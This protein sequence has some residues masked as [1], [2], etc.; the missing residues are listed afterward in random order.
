MYHMESRQQMVQLKNGHPKCLKVLHLDH[1][2]ITIVYS[3][4]NSCYSQ[5][6]SHHVGGREGKETMIKRTK[7]G[8]R[9]KRDGVVGR[10]SWVDLGGVP[11][12]HRYTQFF[13]KNTRM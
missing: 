8:P 6:D 5:I 11:G 9:V 3:Q 2:T 7:V 4:I 13:W 1:S 10:R 12:W